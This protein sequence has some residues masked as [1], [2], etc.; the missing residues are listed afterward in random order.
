[1]LLQAVVYNGM[2]VLQPTAVVGV[3]RGMSLDQLL[4]LLLVGRLL[5]AGHLEYQIGRGARQL[6]VHP[7]QHGLVLK[8]SSKHTN[9]T[10]FIRA[11][12]RTAEKWAR[13][14]AD[15]ANTLDV[16]IAELYEYPEEQLYRGGL[17]LVD[18]GLLQL[19][20]DYGQRRHQLHC[21]PLRT[22]HSPVH[23]RTSYVRTEEVKDR[24]QSILT[25]ASMSLASL[26]MY[27]GGKGLRQVSKR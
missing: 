23:L 20:G 18:V 13:T 9:L 21:F 12:F 7:L 15:F 27:M 5:G 11:T 3:K 1:M 2:K 17:A 6:R 19:L 8:S 25:R 24:A 14:Y 4:P 16:Q 10:L 22:K 26:L